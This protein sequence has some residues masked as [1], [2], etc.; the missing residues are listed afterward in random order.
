[1]KLIAPTDFVA[2]THLVSS[3]ATEVHSAYNAAT[4][5]AKDA[6]VDY[7]THIYQSLVNSN[8]G[9]QPDLSPTFWVL[10]GPDNT[11]A[12]FDDQVS[13]ATT[14]TSPLTVVLATGLANAVALFGLVGTQVQVSVTDGAGGPSVY[15]RTV[16]LDG[17][18]IF[19]WYQY[20]F[21]PYVQVEEV[22]L[23]DLP[24]YANARMTVSLTGA[25][26]LQIGQLVFGNQYELG[27][28]EY[29]ASLGIVD[30][31]RKETD[32]FGTTTF[33]QRAFSKRM[34]LRLMLDTVQIARVQQVLARVRAK[35]AVWVGVP[36]DQLFR[37]LTVYGF[38]RDFNI[39]IAYQLKSYCTLEIEGLV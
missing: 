5:Y 25:G 7:G 18:F 1:M 9:N 15:S 20:F 17:T 27:D 31:S 28:A 34:N 16:S 8:T 37:P 38:F 10:I 23:T 36:T 32:E 6:F 21:E 30:Y 14:A 2:A 33:V 13:T 29:G 3:T 39:D 26:T 22:V 19:D 24:P 4:T 11:H 12:M 35:P